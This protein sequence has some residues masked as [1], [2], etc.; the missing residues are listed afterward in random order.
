MKLINKKHHIST[1]Y[2]QPQKTKILPKYTEKS[3]INDIN[4]CYNHVK[5]ID[6]SVH[7]YR[8]SLSY[9]IFKP[10]YE[11]MCR[12]YEYWSNTKF[13]SYFISILDFNNAHINMVKIL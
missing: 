12:D 7:A 9:V 6:Q 4:I 11:K 3:N 8:F 1:Y 2:K 10:G 5:Y 13:S